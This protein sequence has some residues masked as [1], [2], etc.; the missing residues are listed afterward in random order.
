MIA[1]ARTAKQGLVV[2]LVY[3][4]AQDALGYLRGRTPRY[5]VSARRLFAIPQAPLSGATKDP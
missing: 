4:L 1:A 5:I 3:G 2:G